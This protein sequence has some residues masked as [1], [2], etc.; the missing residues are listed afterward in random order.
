[1]LGAQHRARATAVRKHIAFC[2]DLAYGHIYPS[3]G[4]ASELVRREYEVSY[5][6]PDSFAAKIRESGA[7]PRR[8]E[9]PLNYRSTLYPLAITN[10]GRYDFGDENGE[11]M[12]RLLKV[13][14][15]STTSSMALLKSMY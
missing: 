5:A 3:L 14:S 7:N 8:F 9:P 10:D 2:L 1:M 13:R 6:V 11:F 4:I 12:R 15:E